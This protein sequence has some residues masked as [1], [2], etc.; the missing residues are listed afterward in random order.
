MPKKRAEPVREEPDAPTPPKRAKK[1]KPPRAGAD[2]DAGPSEPA[3]RDPRAADTEAPSAAE[4]ISMFSSNA[5]KLAQTRQVATVKIPSV[6]TTEAAV[7]TTFPDLGLDDWLVTTCT[8]RLA[9]VVRCGC[10]LAM[11]SAT[12]HV[13]CAVCRAWVSSSPRRCRSGASRLYSQ[14][15][16]H[17]V[18]TGGTS[19]HYC[20][21]TCYTALWH[22]LL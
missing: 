11:E 15:A 1:K 13:V 10:P 22:V 4:G 17:Y 12:C 5:V 21:V 6:I 8:V 19:R 16:T 9:A 14:V 2:D 7:R 18:D 20:V 3:R